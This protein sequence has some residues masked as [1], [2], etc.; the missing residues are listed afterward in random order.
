MQMTSHASA[1]KGRYG[2]ALTGDIETAGGGI[3]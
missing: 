3:A 1:V 2:S